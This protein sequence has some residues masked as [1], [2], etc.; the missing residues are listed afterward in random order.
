MGHKEDDF[1]QYSKYFGAQRYEDKPWYAESY[2]D[3]RAHY[4]LFSA[5][6]V[7]F[8]NVAMSWAAGDEE[9]AWMNKV[10]AQHPERVAIINLHEFMLTTGGLGPIPQRILDEVV[11]KNPNVR[12]VMSGHY[13]DAFTKTYD[14]DDNGDG[15]GDRTVTAMLFDYQALP[16]GG[17][18]YLRMMHFD[19][20]AKKMMVRTYSPS[21]DDYNSEEPSLLGPADNPNLYQQFDVS[22]EQLGII[23]ETK[24]TLKTDAL[25]V[26]FLSD[27]VIG[28][29]ADVASG[30]FGSTTW[31]K[32]S[33][34][35]HSWYVRSEDPYGGTSYSPTQTF[36][37]GDKPGGDDKIPGSSGASSFGGALAGIVGAAVGIASAVG[38][39]SW[40][41][42]A[43]PD[44][45]KRLR[46]MFR[47]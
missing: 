26:D 1:T 39:V 47:F 41:V 23:P 44:V 6:G 16:E 3:N 18:G 19:N 8:I 21:L 43:N 17:Q 25:G 11:A 24:R 45:V 40:L 42:Q 2:Q 29:Q 4:D 9:V 22:Y 37:I 30:E 35:R 36:Q 15:T 34:G 33:A 32:L 28:T 46:E 13:H 20:E 27:E 12:M 7:D 14:F 5:G 38:L 31:K 10:L